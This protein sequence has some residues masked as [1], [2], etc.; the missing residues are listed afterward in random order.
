MAKKRGRTKRRSKLVESSGNSI[1]KDR[2]ISKVLRNLVLYLSLFL[3]SVL[4]YQ[5]LTNRV[6]L[7]LFWILSWGFGCISLAFFVFLLALLV[8]RLFKK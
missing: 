5:I 7:T 2:R 1:S 6:F 8:L 4:L 3:V